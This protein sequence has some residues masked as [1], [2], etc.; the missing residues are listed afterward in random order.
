MELGIFY[1][2]HIIRFPDGAFLGTVCG[3]PI[4][5]EHPRDVAYFDSYDDAKSYIEHINTRNGWY[6][7]DSKLREG[8]TIH[9][10]M[11]STGLPQ[12]DE[13]G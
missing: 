8:L 11:V 10:L 7:T 13:D 2:K 1:D 9:E 4:K 5:A 6:I 3:H 12:R